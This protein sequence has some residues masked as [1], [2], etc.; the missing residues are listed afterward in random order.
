[1]SHVSSTIMICLDDIIQLELYYMSY[2]VEDTPC[3]CSRARLFFRVHIL[4]CYHYLNV[5]YLQR[6][7]EAV[8]HHFVLF[9]PFIILLKTFPTTVGFEKSV[10]KLPTVYHMNLPLFFDR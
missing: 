1:M 10:L 4:L 2:A 3:M 5:W 7:S 9:V 6:A 8:T